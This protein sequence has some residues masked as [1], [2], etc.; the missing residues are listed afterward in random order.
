MQY[1]ELAILYINLMWN[2]RYMQLIYRLCHFS[3]E[4]CFFAVKAL[5]TFRLTIY[6]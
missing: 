5:I 2:N 4:R 1:T 6:Y 3:P